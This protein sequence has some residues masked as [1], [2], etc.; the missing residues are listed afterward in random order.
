VDSACK[1][2]DRRPPHGR[3]KATREGEDERGGDGCDLNIN[4]IHGFRRRSSFG[5]CARA[6]QGGVGSRDPLHVCTP[7]GPEKLKRGVRGRDGARGL[8]RRARERACHGLRMMGV[9]Q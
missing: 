6:F 5:R 1:P 3:A 4:Y 7:R 9:R 8:R 2:S